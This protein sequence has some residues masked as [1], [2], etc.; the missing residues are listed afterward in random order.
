LRPVI[1]VGNLAVGGS[2]KTPVV[3]ALARWLLSEGERP[4]VLSRGYARKRLADGIVVV[5]DRERVLETVA[6]SGDEPQMLARALPGVPV[7]A[8]T[9]RFLAGCIAERR[10]GCTVH[11]LDDGFQHFPLHRD[12]DLLLASPD[13]LHERVLPAGRLREPM[14]A[15]TAAD[16][17][18]VT[19][20]DPDVAALSSRLQVQCGFRVVQAF[21]APRLVD[22]FASLA[23]RTTSMRAVAVAG[24][25]RP[26]RFFDAARAQGWEVVKELVFRDHHWF[27]R[28][29]LNRI[30]TAARDEGADIILTTEKD[31]VRLL[32]LPPGPV[33]PPFAYL[34]M[35]VTIEPAT[36]FTAWLRAR[37]MERGARPQ[38]GA[39]FSQ[40]DSA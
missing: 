18:L 38:R 24:I 26:R 6:G 32:D 40:P 29:D 19:G 10:F 17:L 5:S 11:L 27:T 13:D 34:P 15:A 4:S 23:P 3:A 36:D 21:G 37:L 31:A 8:G 7:L 14:E 30:L 2:G 20:A 12:I 39:G 28:S 35:T 33:E 1:S 25:A 16:A 22:P 9:D